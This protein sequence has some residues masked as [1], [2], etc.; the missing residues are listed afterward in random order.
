MIN[1]TQL[2]EKLNIRKHNCV[3]MTAYTNVASIEEF[4][5]AL[6]KRV[7]KQLQ[8]TTNNI[9]TAELFSAEFR[10]Q[11]YR[12]YVSTTQ[13]ERIITTLSNFARLTKN[14]EL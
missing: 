12:R 11:V 7:T 1:L 3:S 2:K 5:G 13:T 8:S 4:D 6:E 10:P 9:I 14:R